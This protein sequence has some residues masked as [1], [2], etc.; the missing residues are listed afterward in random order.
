MDVG[1]NVFTAPN[2][3]IRFWVVS[4]SSQSKF[5]FFGF[6]QEPKASVKSDCKLLAVFENEAVVVS[7]LL[8]LQA[9]KKSKQEIKIRIY[10]Y[11]SYVKLNQK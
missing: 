5:G 11:Y 6:L 4:I 7:C 8:V 2:S 3:Y 9:F 10:S 1:I